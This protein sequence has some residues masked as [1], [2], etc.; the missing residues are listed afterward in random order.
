MN[1]TRLEIRRGVGTRKNDN[2]TRRVS[3]GGG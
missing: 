3:R 1:L 2:S